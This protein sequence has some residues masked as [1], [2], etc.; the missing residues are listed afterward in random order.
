MHMPVSQSC[1]RALYGQGFYQDWMEGWEQSYH[2]GINATLYVITQQN[3]ASYV[4]A[5]PG[6][7]S[8][9]MEVEPL[10]GKPKV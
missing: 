1:K 5:M 4:H 6:F 9:S 8:I 2:T 3:F 7:L 10:T